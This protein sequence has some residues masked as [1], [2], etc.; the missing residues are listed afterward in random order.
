MG[1]RGEIGEFGFVRL[2]QIDGQP[3]H[4]AGMGDEA[5]RRGLLFGHGQWEPKH[6]AVLGRAQGGEDLAAH[7]EVGM[8]VVGPLL[9]P[10]E[11]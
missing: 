5:I 8:A 2:N 11:A 3:A 9:G 10:V 7:S 6:G 1:E 4:A